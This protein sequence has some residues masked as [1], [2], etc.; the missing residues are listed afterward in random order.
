MKYICLA[1]TADT[2]RVAQEPGGHAG[3][4]YLPSGQPAGADQ[5]VF[6]QITKLLLQFL[7]PEGGW[8]KDGF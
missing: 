8:R 7:N 1:G 6:V 2:V 3:R 5:E 4:G